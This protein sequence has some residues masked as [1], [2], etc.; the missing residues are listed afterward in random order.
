MRAVV[1]GVLGLVGGFVVGVVLFEGGPGIEWPPI[2][3]A[4]SS[5]VAAPLADARLRRGP[6]RS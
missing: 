1:L 2:V 5:A 3:L 6:G 4:I